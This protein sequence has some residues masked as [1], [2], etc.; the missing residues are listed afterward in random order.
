[1]ATF[2]IIIFQDKKGKD[3]FLWESGSSRGPSS[4][5]SS[6]S[7]ESSSS[8]DSSSE[9]SESQ[10]EEESSSEEK[11]DSKLS[12]SSSSEESSDKESEEEA[13]KINEKSQNEKQL[14]AKPEVSKPKSNLDLLLDLSDLG[15][16]IPVMTPSL[17]GFL[18][19]ST[20]INVNPSPSPLEV[21]PPAYTNT[22]PLELINKING[23]GLSATYRFTRTPHILSPSMANINLVFTNNTNDDICDIRVGKKHLG[24][25]LAIHDFAN[26][27]K[28]PPSGC[29]P[30]S[31]GIDF[32]DTIQPANFEIVCSLGTD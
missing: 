18:T 21:I 10:Y 16:S 22:K 23:K 7:D 2:L 4:N 25:D 19:P 8:S 5:N 3:M 12:S 28:L 24:V 29:L 6:D 9:D 20:T 30:A 27:A 14:L 26:I 32:N 1:M 17:G 15:S 13:Q 11:S 31:L